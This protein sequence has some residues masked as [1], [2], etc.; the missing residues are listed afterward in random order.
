[1]AFGGISG[2]QTEPRFVNPELQAHLHSDCP[3]I[4]CAFDGMAQLTEGSEALHCADVAQAEH[5]TQLSPK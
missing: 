3:L 5:A 4:H 2:Q 1:M